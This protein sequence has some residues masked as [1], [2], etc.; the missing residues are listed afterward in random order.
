LYFGTL[1]PFDSGKDAAQRR[2]TWELW[3]KVVLACVPAS[4]VGIPLDDWMEE[5]LSTPW[6]VSAALIACGIAFI[7]IETLRGRA[8]MRDIGSSEQR[9]AQ[10][11]ATV[12]SVL[13]PAERADARARIQHVEDLDWLTALGIGMFQVLSLVPGTSRSGSTI[14]GGLVIGCSRVVASEFTF[15]LSIPVMFGASALRLVKYLLRGGMPTLAEWQVLA[16]GCVVAFAVS[17]LCIRLLMGFVRKHDFRPF[18][19]YRILLGVVVLVY[20]ALRA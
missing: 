2:A 4:L 9:G 10:H 18:G 16:V 5:H 13:S 8:A 6:V 12:P 1:N 3:G 7:A 20:F 19:W 15:F 17:M 11:L 14:I